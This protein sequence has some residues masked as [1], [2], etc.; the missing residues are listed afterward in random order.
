MAEDPPSRLDKLRARQASALLDRIERLLKAW[1]PILQAAFL[2]CFDGLRDRVSVPRLILLIDAKDIEGTIAAL[3]LERAQFRPLGA[4]VEALYEAAALDAT[5][6]IEVV[7]GPLGLRI[8]PLFDVKE[9]AAQQWIE[10]H[11]TALISELT[12]Q[13]RELVRTALAPLRSGLDPMMTGDTPEKLALDLVGRVSKVTGHREG[14]IIGLTARQAE[15]AASYE[16]ELSGVPDAKALTRKLR[17]RRFDRSVEKAIREGRP[18]PEKTRAAMIATYRN[19]ALR[20]RA[21]AIAMNE[22]HEVAHAAQITAWEQAI[23]R[24]AVTEDRIRR[25]WVTAQDDHVR[26]MHAEVPKMNPG[27][28]GL[29][30]PFNTPKGQFLQPGW[31]FDPGCRCRVLIRV[32]ED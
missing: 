5:A 13:Q 22:A 14:G 30:A 2:E 12:E 10:S 24:G 20:Y 1:E 32:L 8:A 11:A 17:D 18:L 28:V 21:E 31:R 16:R 4:A 27:G 9:P 19:R 15:W 7:Q 23:A 29:H 25:H 26:P 3:G 6:G